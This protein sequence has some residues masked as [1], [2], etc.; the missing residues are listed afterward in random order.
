MP[1]DSAAV[2]RAA[3]SYAHGRFD[4]QVLDLANRLNRE[5]VD[6]EIDLY[7]EAPPQGWPQWILDTMAARVVL[8]V[9]TAEYAERLESRASEGVGRGVAFEGRLLRQRVYDDQGRNE[10]IVPIIFDEADRKYVPLFL[11]D[12]AYYDISTNGGYEALYRR[13]TRQPKHTKPPLG[14]LKEMP[15]EGAVE[16]PAPPV[17]TSG[18][19]RMVNLEIR[20]LSFGALADALTFS[21]IGSSVRP[22]ADSH[23]VDFFD[24]DDDERIESFVSSLPGWQGL[25]AMEVSEGIVLSDLPELTLQEFGKSRNALHLRL[26]G[27]VTVR[28]SIVGAHF[29]YDV[30]R[31]LATVFAVS[32]YLHNKYKTYPLYAGTFGYRLLEE[33]YPK[34]VKQAPY[35]APYRFDVRSSFPEAMTSVIV[36]WSRAS[37]PIGLTKEEVSVEL[38]RFWQSEFA[39]AG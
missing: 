30:E 27:S 38:S 18:E 14:I 15:A 22:L 34:D 8:V 13:L 23:T 24:A 39:E 4:H 1:A 32:R 6:C 2:F 17:I 26:D 19:P 10:G 33:A 16:L 7:N 25:H 11:R 35:E 37:W 20:R 5:G 12:V 36:L 28:S 9:C 21:N 29:L 31:T 3:I